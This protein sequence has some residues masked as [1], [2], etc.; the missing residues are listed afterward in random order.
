MSIMDII[1][2]LVFGFGF[3]WLLQRA[4][5]TRYEK[6]VNAFRFTD[7]TVLKF[8]L[9]AIASGVI[10]V[11]LFVDFGWMDPSLINPTYI[12]GNLVGGLIFGVG[13]AAAGLCP[14][15]T[16]AGVGRG[17]LDYLVPGFLGFIAGGAIFGITYPYFFPT[18]SAQLKF[19]NITI[20]EAFDVNPWL[21][22]L[23]TFLAIVFLLYLIEK[24]DLRRLDKI[25]GETTRGKQSAVY[26][27][28]EPASISSK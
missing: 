6:I 15:T 1:Y 25:K 22:V 12:T 13:M 26:S 17:N 23:F 9:S 24:L 14:G 16:V 8:M 19:G 4:Q 27:A 28:G 21:F 11:R 20:P 3:G 2:A 10:F 7:Q 18:I 5:L